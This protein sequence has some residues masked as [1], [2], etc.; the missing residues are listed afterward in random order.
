MLSMGARAERL[1]AHRLVQLE[2]KLDAAD[3]ETAST[4]WAEYYR[5]LDLWLRV[6]QPAAT[7]PAIT[8]AMLAER[9]NAK[10]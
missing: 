9:F 3:E 4:V 10:P 8:K 7:T 6:R 2:R 1:L 5:C